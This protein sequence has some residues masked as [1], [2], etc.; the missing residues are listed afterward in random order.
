MHSVL[1]TPTAC[2]EARAGG[3]FNGSWRLLGTP[4]QPEPV[5]FPRKTLDQRFAV[6]LLNSMYEAVDSLDFIPMDEFQVRF[7][8]LRQSEYEAYTLQCSPAVIQQ[9]DLT[10]PAYFDFISFAQLGTV[11]AALDRP[12]SIFQEF[13]EECDHQLR[14]VVRSADTGGDAALPTRLQRE[15]GD[16][17]YSGLLQGFRGEQFGAPP[18]LPASAPVAELAAGVQSLLRIFASRGYALDA[19]VSD[20]A[21][22]R[23]CASVERHGACPSAGT[24]SVRLEGPATLWGMGA[25]ASRRAMLNAYDAMVTE[26]FLRRSG[27]SASYELRRTDTAIEQRWVLV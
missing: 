13:C 10:N 24:F 12:R 14:T 17:I 22:A 26:A 16:R 27:C 21:P 8:K 3:V 11:S 2:Q 23:S 19:R 25:L 6:L 7:W 5:L 20:V 4:T 15:A 9:G 18:P 1:S